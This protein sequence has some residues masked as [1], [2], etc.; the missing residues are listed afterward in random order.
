MTNLIGMS[1][2][3]KFKKKHG[4]DHQKGREHVRKSG[5]HYPIEMRNFKALSHVHGFAEIVKLDASP[6]TQIVVSHSHV[7]LIAPRDLH[8]YVH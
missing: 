7:I 4:V 1:Q 2:Q 6:T 3:I 8:E 5:K